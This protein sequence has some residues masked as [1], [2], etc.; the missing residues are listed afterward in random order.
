MN[1]DERAPKAR[2]DAAEKEAK[3][4]VRVID[5]PTIVIPDTDKITPDKK[6]T[7]L[8]SAGNKTKVTVPYVAPPEL[9]EQKVNGIHDSV[10][11]KKR[12][13]GYYWLIAG[14]IILVSMYM[15]SSKSSAPQPAKS[16]AMAPR[17]TTNKKAE[18]A[19]GVGT[20]EEYIPSESRIDFT[21]PSKEAVGHLNTILG[22]SLAD[23]ALL[24]GYAQAIESLGKPLRGDRKIARKNLDE[25]LSLLQRNE[26]EVA[27]QLLLTALNADPLDVEV[28]NNLGFAL[29]KAGHASLA[30]NYLY[31]A[32]ALAPQ[33]AGAWFNLAELYGR[34]GSTEKALA[35]NILT[36]RFSSNM[37][38]TKAY[39]VELSEK[40][41]NLGLQQSARAALEAIEKNFGDRTLGAGEAR[42]LGSQVQSGNAGG[43]DKRTYGWQAA[44]SIACDVIY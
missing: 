7:S 10:E 4:S 11:I 40:E 39:L 35:A 32:L 30:E 36:Y 6:A 28:A 12:K 19:N 25:A 23:G 5:P 33:R 20:K 42:P 16:A 22:S 34:S 38:R 17:N 37:T 24:S 3:Q 8:V 31:Y 43:G 14:A 13:S 1:F 2:T 41:P 15:I 21:F 27:S 29:L 9:R 44:L 26:F 18:P